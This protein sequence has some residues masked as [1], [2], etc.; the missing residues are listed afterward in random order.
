[1]DCLAKIGGIQMAEF[2]GWRTRKQVAELMKVSPQ[3]VTREIMRGNLQAVKVGRQYRI[4][5]ASL[6]DYVNRGCL[7]NA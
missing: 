3:T 5:E 4:P 6:R 7:A 1:M 2:M